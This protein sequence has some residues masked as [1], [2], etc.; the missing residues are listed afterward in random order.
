MVDRE[1]RASFWVFRM[2]PW[3]L[4]LTVGIFG[5]GLL[6]PIRLWSSARTSAAPI[7]Q[8]VTLMG[9]DFSGKSPMEARAALVDLAAQINRAPVDA[10]VV[11]TDG[12]TY[13][14][15]DQTGWA[16]DVEQTLFRLSAAAPGGKVQP[17][18]KETRP[19]HRISDYPD[20][21]IRQAGGGQKALGLLINV[22]WGEQELAQ[23]LPVMR[24]FGAKVTFFVSGNWAKR[25]PDLLRQ[26]AADGHEIAT[27]GNNLANGPSV[28]ARN[29]T[30]QADIRT[31]VATIEG[32]TK[33]PV[34]YYAPHM[35]EVS[36]E[37]VKTASSLHLRTVLYSI[38]TIDWSPNT[39]A[40]AVMRKIQGAKPGDLILLHPKPLTLS[41][42]PGM[43]QKLQDKGLQP[44]TLTQLL[45]Q[46]GD[47]PTQTGA[48]M[49]LH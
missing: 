9:H 27:H 5:L 3:I 25:N 33:Q 43:L 37:I 47:G 23:M 41:L 17:A 6:V 28:L 19:V 36:P 35:S 34:R 29:G 11:E 38:D 31:S 26:M 49:D 44:V 40:G 15:P 45:V 18:L 48:P 4:L 46:N 2:N 32:I 8:G 30:L 24:Q 21:I 10:R 14:T 42:L 22:D 12:V 1:V 20:S 7:A 16:L 39:T 13:V